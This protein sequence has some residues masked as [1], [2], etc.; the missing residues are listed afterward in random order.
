MMGSCY[1]RALYLAAVGCLILAG[2]PSAHA[3]ER[4]TADLLDVF[5]YRNVG[6]FRAGSWI[7][8]IAVPETPPR[9]HLYTFYIGSRTGGLWKTVNNGTTFEPIFDDQDALSIGAV[10]LAPSDPDIVWVGTGEAYN[11]RS[12]YSGDGVYKSTDAGETWTNMG[13]R[14]SHHISRIVI[15]P[16]DPEVVYVASMGHLYSANEQRGVFRTEDGGR[17]WDKVLYI[18]ERIGV[19]DLVMNR[20]D[21]DVL[22]AATY[23]KQRLPWHFEVGGPAS[24]IYRTRDGGASW[25]RLAGGLPTGEIGRIGIDI[26]RRDPDILYAIVEN[27]NTRPPTREE[28]A[29][30]RERGR[31]P[32]ERVIGGEVYRTDDGGAT[33]TKMNPPDVNVGGKA[34]YSFNWIRIDP[35]DD[36]NIFV[37]TVGIANSTDG[38]RTWHDLDWPPERLFPNMFGDVRSLWIDPRDSDRIIAG[39]DGGVNISYD[40]GKTSDYYDNLP[41]GEVYAVGVDMEGPYNIYAGLQ[42]HESWKG[43]SN[44]WSGDVSLEDWVTV[45]TGDG[46]YNVVDPRD[47]RWLYNTS[48]FGDHYRVDQELWVRTEIEPTR[49]EGEPPLRYTWTTPVHISPHDGQTIYTGAQVLLRSPDRGETWH[50]ISPD[51][52]TN[53]PEKIAGEGHIQYCTITTISESAVTA[54][55]IWVG[56]DD[57][58][59]QVTRNHGETWRDVTP[60]LVAAGAPES[61][62]VSRVVASNLREG[63]AYVAKSGYR[64]DDFRPFLYKTTDFG[65]TWTVVSGNLPD[66]PI[67]VIVEDR[68]NPD[69]LFVGTDRG[70]HVSIDAGRR[71]VALQNNMPAVVVR[72]LVVHAREDDLVAGTYGRGI[73]ITDIS[74]LQELTAEV[75]ARDVHLFDIEPQGRRIES[76]WGNYSL[77][78][79]RHVVTP[80]EPN[81]LTIYYYL[82]DPAPERVRITVTDRAGTPVRTLEGE[83]GAGINRVLWDLRDA[84]EEWVAP[85]EYT[86]TLV[87]GPHTRTRTAPVQEPV[88]LPRSHD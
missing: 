37:T 55:V 88:H 60:N 56:T 51:L 81:G 17:S 72:D 9:A 74:P 32:Q 75:L 68:E 77:Y 67:N 50:E 41:L 30:D 5:Q 4:F 15:H 29:E 69:L 57:G 35:N 21:P 14:D 2:P 40:G 54:G 1:R 22:Y 39:T 47:S 19:I 20:D 87:S 11:A 65:A 70:V 63:T 45:G 27:A 78:G 64:R 43:P 83:S 85:G 62:W 6:P 84:E 8:A 42:D 61:Y 79:D 33:W 31:E 18:D 80:N 46:M 48:Q 58:K 13:L 44:G 16:E 28:A 49:A 82:K 52:T 25:T 23:E 59:V 3:Q 76:G 34:P 53:D 86:V 38:G 24:G 66:A 7:S 71:W 36:Q 26:Y 10:A 12:S 73:F